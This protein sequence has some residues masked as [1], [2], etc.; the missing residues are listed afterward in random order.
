MHNGVFEGERAKKQKARILILGESHHVSTDPKV[1]TDKV[2]GVP[3]SYTTTSVVQEHLDKRKTHDFLTKIA[4]TFGAEEE[5]AFWQ[6]VYFG[7]YIDV[8]CGIGSSLAERQIADNR[9]E[10]NDQLFGFVNEHNISKIFCSSVLAYKNLPDLGDSEESKRET[11]GMR[12]NRRVFLRQC[13]YKAGT[14][15][16]GTSV[17]LQQNLHVYGISHPQ[18]KGGYSPEMYAI[19]LKND[20]LREI[21]APSIN[22]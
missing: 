7:N 15:H 19:V 21:P 22:K 14:Q 4:K 18:A 3:A 17:I 1:T 11:I 20:T 6:S 10:Y 5:D 9:K 16:K 8:L 13:Q 12:G 2:A